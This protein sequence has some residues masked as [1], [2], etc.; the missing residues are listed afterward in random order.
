MKHIQLISTRALLA[1]SVLASLGACANLEPAA[2][3]PHPRVVER[4]LAGERLAERLT[5]RLAERLAERAPE[6]PQ[7]RSPERSAER[8]P[9]RNTLTQRTPR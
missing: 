3:L 6:R 8:G 7:E 2:P 9:D 4:D 1:A 5:E